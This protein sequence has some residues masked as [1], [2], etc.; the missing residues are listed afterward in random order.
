MPVPGSDDTVEIVN[1]PTTTTQGGLS[2]LF[3]FFGKTLGTAAGAVGSNALSNFLAE[4]TAKSQ[5]KTQEMLNRYHL[6]NP[7]TGPNDPQ[8]AQRA[9]N[10][11]FLERY[12]PSDLLYTTDAGGVRKFTVTYFVIVGVLLLG[13]FFVLRKIFRK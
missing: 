9:A 7:S 13:L 12:L 1:N 5:A 11:T 6:A 10:R 2:S 3:Q 4:Q 8:D